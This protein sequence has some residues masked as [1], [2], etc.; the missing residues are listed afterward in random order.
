MV[1][2]YIDQGLPVGLID[3]DFRKAF[4]K[5]PHKRLMLKIKSLGIIEIVFDWDIF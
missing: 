1:T 3:L 4:D 5:I 2:N